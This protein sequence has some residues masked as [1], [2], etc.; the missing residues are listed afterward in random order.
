MAGNFQSV[1]AEVAARFLHT[2][3]LFDDQAFIA[4]AGAKN[5][6]KKVKKLVAPTRRSQ[7][8]SED[9]LDD[10]SSLEAKHELDAKRLID[11][12]AEKGLIC[13][14]LVPGQG[15]NPVPRT[16]AAARRSDIVIL[17]WRIF[18]DN[19]EITTNLVGEI[20]R[21]DGSRESRLRVISIYT[22]EP[23]F[24]DIVSKLKEELKKHYTEYPL[25]EEAFTLTKGPVRIVVYAKQD[26]LFPSPSREL[27]KRI[28][29]LQD[30]PNKLI[31][32]FSVATMG[33]MSNVVLESL[34]ALRS[35]THQIITKFCPELDAAYLTHRALL[36]P[37]EEAELH[38]IPL[39]LSEILAVLEDRNVSK[40]VSLDNITKWVDFRI[41]EGLR[42]YRK[43]KM[44]T[45]KNARKAVLEI[46][47]KG[48]RDKTLR[49]SYPQI[50]VLLDRL[51]EESHRP[52]LNEFTKLLQLNGSGSEYDQELALLMSVRSRYESPIPLLTLG[53]IIAEDVDE[54][55]SRY[56]LC[57]QPVCDSLRLK[58]KRNFP[59]LKMSKSAMDASFNYL[60][61]DK[62][63]FVT[64]NLSLRPFQS[65][66]IA[67]KPKAGEREIR[68]STESES[69]YFVSVDTGQQ[70][71]RW[72][73]DLK[74]EHAQR[75][76]NEYSYQISRVGLMESEWLRRWAKK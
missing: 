40:H 45:K 11:L 73:A 72:V 55:T 64:L 29:R 25:K 58:E 26:T 69:W 3:V 76:A 12:F 17:D 13:S 35:N 41:G 59:F 7:G 4:R 53:T 34:A 20:L 39:I 21:A 10:S 70:K 43:L 8:A 24:H 1:S 5:K 62:E 37:P 30:L 65:K 51:R 9:N 60:V 50:R 71:Y 18:D 66:M 61:R 67:F 22:A 42:L 16:V 23:N 31:A 38:L 57:V 19:G 28:V 48:V 14:V 6:S 54:D 27:T 44:K 2:V 68:A 46:A 33:L 47:E 52:A 32:E 49:D 75:V 74:P 56:W 15:E 36:D 63:S